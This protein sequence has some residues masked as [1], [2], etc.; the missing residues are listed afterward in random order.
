MNVSLKQ[1]I[2]IHPKVLKHRHNYQA[3]RVAREHART[4]KTWCDHE[5]HEVWLSV[6]EIAEA[7]LEDVLKFPSPLMCFRPLK[8][9]RLKH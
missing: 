8:R 2:E 7:L 6:I 9:C 5:G 4:L 1:A 3:P